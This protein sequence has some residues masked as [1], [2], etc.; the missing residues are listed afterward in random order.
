MKISSVLMAFVAFGDAGTPPNYKQVE[1]LVDEKRRHP[2]NKL[3]NYNK[4]LNRYTVMLKEG[5]VQDSYTSEELK[6]QNLGKAMARNNAWCNKLLENFYRKDKNEVPVKCSTWFRQDRERRSADGELTV[7]L[8]N[9]PWTALEEC[10]MKALDFEDAEDGE[11]CEDCCTMGEDGEWELPAKMLR[12]KLI[13]EPAD[14]AKA[15]RRVIGAIKKWGN[16]FISDCGG[17]PEIAAGNRAPHYSI[18]RRLLKSGIK[19]DS[20]DKQLTKKILAL[21]WKRVFPA[22]KQVEEGGRTKKV[23][24]KHE[25]FHEQ[26]GI[27]A[28]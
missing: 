2:Q 10:D 7:D 19:N 24:F 17:Q 11:T 3:A 27:K 12:G 4:L 1:R 9:D 25:Q 13:E 22:S 16:K 18:L 14:M 15:M 28:E 8:A 6:K 21:K 20:E 23:H 26:L 5:K